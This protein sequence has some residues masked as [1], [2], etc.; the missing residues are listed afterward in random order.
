MA[1][2]IVQ[3]V[4]QDIKDLEKEFN[5]KLKKLESR[6]PG[7]SINI[8]NKAH[9]KFSGDQTKDFITIWG[10]TKEE[11]GEPIRSF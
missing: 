10:A 3:D 7:V 11:D 1:L 9:P 5:Q 4:I 2:I 8:S 6:L